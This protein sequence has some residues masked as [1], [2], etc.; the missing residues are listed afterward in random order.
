[1]AITL[2]FLAAANG[3]AIYIPMW[4][5][6][7]IVSIA[8]AIAAFIFIQS[9]RHAISP[10]ALSLPKTRDQIGRDIQSIKEHLP[11]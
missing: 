7:V 11:S 10:K 8:A 4:A 6:L 1:A 2:A 9:A 5:G 3:F